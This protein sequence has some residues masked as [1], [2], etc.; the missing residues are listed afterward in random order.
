MS[1]SHTSVAMTGHSH[2]LQNSFSTGALPGLTQCSTSDSAGQSTRASAIE[3]PYK[4]DTESGF[5]VAG[6][7]RRVTIYECP[8]LFLECEELF[9]NADLWI[10]HAETHFGNHPPPTHA[11][12]CFCDRIF[13]D[14]NPNVCWGNRMNHVAGHYMRGDSLR[15]CLPDHALSRYYYQIC[16]PH[17]HPAP[18]PSPAPSVYGPGELVYGDQQP[19]QPP[20]GVGRPQFVINVESRQDRRHQ[21]GRPS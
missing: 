20:P 5:A 19:V 11:I 18:T 14:E 13:D 10:S 7:V 12:C 17:S 1:R 9:Y 4:L 16:Q 8:F 15:R 21:R 6:P 3:Q 2:S